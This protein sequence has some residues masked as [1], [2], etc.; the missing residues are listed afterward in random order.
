MSSEYAVLE[1]A[2]NPKIQALVL[3][4]G[5]LSKKAKQYLQSDHSVPVLGVVGKDDKKS[6]AGHK[7]VSLLVVLGAVDHYHS[8]NLRIQIHAAREP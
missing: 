1:A 7:M 3:I 2:E 5:T 4:S 8:R 6:F